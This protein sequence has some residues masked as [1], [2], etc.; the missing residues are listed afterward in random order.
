MG[1]ITCT[2]ELLGWAGP[3]G[4]RADGMCDICVQRWVN[5]GQPG[6]EESSPVV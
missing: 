6:R 1:T 3:E 5:E 4:F 2:G